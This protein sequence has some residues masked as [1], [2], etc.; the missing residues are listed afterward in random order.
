MKKN[1]F[2]STI[3]GSILG[4]L[5]FADFF[6]LVIWV[7]KDG[8][9]STYSSFFEKLIDNFVM[10]IIIVLPIIILIII[11][12]IQYKLIKKKNVKHNFKW[13]LLY[14]LIITITAVCAFFISFFLFSAL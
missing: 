3:I 4:L 13:Q 11:S 12:I 6:L 9:F 1:I 5:S 10:W 2:I 7:F 8:L 14:S